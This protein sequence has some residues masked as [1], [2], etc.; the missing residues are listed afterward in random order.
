MLIA[1][2]KAKNPI[3]KKTLFPA[4]KFGDDDATDICV[5]MALCSVKNL[6]V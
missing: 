3:P 4:W 1:A 5:T 6:N 2:L